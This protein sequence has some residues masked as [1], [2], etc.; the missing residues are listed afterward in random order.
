MRPHCRVKNGVK[1]IVLNTSSHY[2]VTGRGVACC[3]AHQYI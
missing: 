2:R 3:A 1:P